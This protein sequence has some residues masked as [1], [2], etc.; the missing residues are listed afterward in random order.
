[1]ALTDEERR[2]LAQLEASLAADDPH[3]AS[4]LRGA[5]PKRV[6][7][8][9]IVVAT[10]GLAA[11]IALLIIGMQTDPLVS[12]LGFLVMLVSSVVAVGAWHNPDQPPGS[13]RPRRTPG[14]RRPRTPHQRSGGDFMNRMEERWRRRREQG[15]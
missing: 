4:T 5:R 15:F 9:R 1:M 7:V 6:P 13:P 2:Q 8:R 3:L 11:G 12:V 14:H 10:V